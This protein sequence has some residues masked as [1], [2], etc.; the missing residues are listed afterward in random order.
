MLYR[1]IQIKNK[2]KG[3][4][5]AFDWILL[6]EMPYAS[7]HIPFPFSGTSENNSKYR[8]LFQLINTHVCTGML[9]FIAWSEECFSAKVP[10]CSE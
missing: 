3:H 7:T 2:L 8:I 10:V 5:D 6:K 4:D 9:L 1:I